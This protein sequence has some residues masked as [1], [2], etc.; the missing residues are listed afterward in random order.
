MAKLGI[1]KY[2]FS[3][4]TAFSPNVSDVFFI[5]IHTHIGP[6]L[7]NYS[8]VTSEYTLRKIFPYAQY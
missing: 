4:P 5:H 1:V 7:P 6:I 3:Q 2:C 8:Y